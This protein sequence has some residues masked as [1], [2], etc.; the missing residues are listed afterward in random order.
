[1][2]VQTGDMTNRADTDVRFTDCC[3]LETGRIAV[4][5]KLKSK[6]NDGLWLSTIQVRDA[7]APAAPANILE[8]R[9]DN[10]GPPISSDT[11]WAKSNG[12][13]YPTDKDFEWAQVQDPR[14]EY[15]DN[16]LIGASGWIVA[17]ENSGGDVPFSHPFGFDWEFSIAL[18]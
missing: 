12:E 1:M 11:S 3:L 4:A 14:Q 10:L 13:S 9:F 5:A 6:R 18:D 17:P 7:Q 16:T 2:L 15:D 8:I